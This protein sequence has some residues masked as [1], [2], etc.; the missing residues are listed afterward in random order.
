[1]SWQ[2]LVFQASSAKEKILEEKLDRTKKAVEK[3]RDAVSRELA[4]A[5]GAELTEDQ[6]NRNTGKSRMKVTGSV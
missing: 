2:N 6:K 4:D 3:D 1:M 5:L